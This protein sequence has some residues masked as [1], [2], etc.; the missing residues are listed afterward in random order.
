MDINILKI[1]SDT[2]NNKH[3]HNFTHSMKYKV[4]VVVMRLKFF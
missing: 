1:A 4:K 3:I 2:K